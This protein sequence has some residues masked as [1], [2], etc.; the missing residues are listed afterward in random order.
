[1]S[2]SNMS[3]V[4]N[5]NE[6]KVTQEIPTDHPDDLPKYSAELIG[7]NGFLK[8]ADRMNFYDKAERFTQLNALNT[9]T[10]RNMLHI[11]LSFDPSEKGLPKEQLVNI[12]DRY[13]EAIGFKDQPYLVYKHND[14]SHPHLHIVTN[15]IRSD[16]ARINTFNIGKDKS[17]PARKSIEQ[18]FNLVRAEASRHQK[19]LFELQPVDAQKVIYGSTTETK[20]AMKQAIHE[21]FTKYKYASLPEYNAALR[22]Y[23]ITADPG[24]PDSR[25][26][27]HGGLVYRI[28]DEQG[29]KVGVPI[30]ASAFYFQPTLKN[31]EANFEKNIMA[32]EKHLQSIRD[33]I[34]LTR[35]KDPDSLREHIEDLS[36]VR[37]EVVIRQNEK[38]RAYGVT[39]VDKETKTVIKGS[40]LGKEY[41]ANNFLRRFQ[42]PKEKTPTDK[43]AKNPSPDLPS[44]DDRQQNE[45]SL[46]LVAGFNPKVP[47][48]LSNL[49]QH[50]ETFG[51]SPY[52][53][54]EQQKIRRHRLK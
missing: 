28:L 47:Q 6:K 39:L 51:R 41:T 14:A 36:A 33:R 12:A 42:Q 29:N 43:K 35:L 54:E 21:V 1:M 50:D 2:S 31:V 27:K 20:T 9:R 15:I 53:L 34:D 46:P 18:E 17:E 19:K 3:A 22:L 11:S 48:I 8:E 7:A 23:N 16:G 32:R 13:M 30:K 49:M 40:D 45:P 25:L 38:G 4:L 26:R 24:S 10:E 5:Y 44:P 52:E 37:I